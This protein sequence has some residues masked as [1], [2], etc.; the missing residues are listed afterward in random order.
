[1][2]RFLLAFPR[3]SRP[4]SSAASRAVPEFIIKADPKGVVPLEGNANLSPSEIT[5]H[6]DEYIVGQEKAKRVLAV[7]V[8]DRWRRMNV[9]DKQMSK[10]IMPMK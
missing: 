5:K 9:K 6:L 7:A 8:R 10:E 3:I 1:M 2:L 4:F